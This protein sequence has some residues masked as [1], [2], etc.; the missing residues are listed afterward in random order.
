MIV[1]S[2]GGSKPLLGSILA[3]LGATLHYVLDS[4][5]HFSEFP[6]HQLFSLGQIVCLAELTASTGS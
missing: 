6:R 3:A 2:V 5:H 4:R 1:S